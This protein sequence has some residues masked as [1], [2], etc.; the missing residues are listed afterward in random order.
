[1]Q[2]KYLLNWMFDVWWFGGMFWEFLGLE[3]RGGSETA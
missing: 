2:I 3:K 1:M